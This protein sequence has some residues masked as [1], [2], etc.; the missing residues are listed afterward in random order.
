MLSKEALKKQEMQQ[1][2]YVVECSHG[3]VKQDTNP[4]ISTKT[5]GHNDAK[6]TIPN[7]DELSADATVCFL[8]AVYTATPEPNANTIATSGQMEL[9][10]IRFW[11]L[12]SVFG[13]FWSFLFVI[14]PLVIRCHLRL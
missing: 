4:K 2:L 6:V 7:P 12:V 5:T 11:L 8:S 10:C 9:M 1:L 3:I 14:S 13:R